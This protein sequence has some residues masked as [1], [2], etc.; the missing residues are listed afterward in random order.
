MVEY[1]SDGYQWAEAAVP[2][3]TDSETMTMT[4]DDE[5]EGRDMGSPTSAAHVG[6]PPPLPPP[7]PPP[8]TDPQHAGIQMGDPV[9][10]TTF[11]GA[12]PIETI[13]ENFFE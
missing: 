1:H 7:I 11:M 4:I 10:P 12:S 6:T 3:S 5:D 9:S 8:E 2:P 13:H